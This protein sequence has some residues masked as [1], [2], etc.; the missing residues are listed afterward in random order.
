[1]ALIQLAFFLLKMLGTA[2]FP[3][4]QLSLQNNLTMGREQ[5]DPSQEWACETEVFGGER[6][7]T[8]L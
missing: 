3:G 7:R 2:H 8:D 4:F 5:A 6:G 1:M